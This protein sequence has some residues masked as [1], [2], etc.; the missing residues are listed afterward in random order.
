MI[1]WWIVI[2]I[3]PVLAMFAV[4]VNIYKSSNNT[5][6]KERIHVVFITGVA[7]M[8]L[9]CF[10]YVLAFNQAEKIEKDKAAKPQ[11]EQVTE[12]FYRKIK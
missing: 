11:Y 6:E 12:T 8:M 7:V 4:T 1:I 9:V 3:F 5:S 10:Y 2:S